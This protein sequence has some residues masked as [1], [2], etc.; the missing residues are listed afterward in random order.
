[1]SESNVNSSCSAA[2]HVASNFMVHYETLT[3]A[4]R[5]DKVYGEKYTLRNEGN[6]TNSSVLESLTFFPFL[7]LVC[8]EFFWI[9]KLTTGEKCR[10]SP[11]KQSEICKIDFSENKKLLKIP[12]S[13]LSQ[14]PMKKKMLKK[15]YSRGIHVGKVFWNSTN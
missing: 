14:L 10:H 1:M 15:D 9:K 2:A 6:E 3:M 11:T 12:L 8:A 13:S 5:N 4:A 7:Q